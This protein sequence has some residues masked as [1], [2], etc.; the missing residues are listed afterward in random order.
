MSMDTLQQSLDAFL[1]KG[2]LMWKEFLEGLQ[3]QGKDGK[4]ISV[5]FWVN[6]QSYY[7]ALGVLGVMVV[8]FCIGVVFVLQKNNQLTSR[9]WDLKQLSEYAMGW[10]QQSEV[11]SDEKDSLPQTIGELVVMYQTSQSRKNELTEKLDFKKSVYTEFLKNLLLPSLNIWKDPYTKEVDLS[12]LGKKYLDQNPYQDISLLSQW[13][14]IIKDSGKDVWDNEVVNMKIGDIEELANGFFRI[15]INIAFKSDSK[16]AFLLLVD[17]LSL[18]SNI[19]NLWLL[20]DFTYYLFDVIRTQKWEEIHQ[21]MEEYGM[22][23]SKQ[24][25][26]T[27]NTVISRY[28]YSW[29]FTGDAVPNILIDESVI[30]EAIRDSIVCRGD[31]SDDV[32]YFMFRNKYRNIPWLAYAI[33]LEGLV[34]KPL[35]LKKFY[36]EIPPLI[37]IESFTF[38]KAKSQGLSLANTNEYLWNINFSIY[39]RGIDPADA[40]EISDKLTASCF[41]SGSKNSLDLSWALN[42]VQASILQ[43]QKDGSTVGKVENRNA[44]D[45]LISRMANLIELRDTLTEDISTYEGLSPYNKIIKNF[46]YYRMLQNASLCSASS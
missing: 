9:T 22:S 44:D 4:K 27:Y 13:S 25:E 8:T 42:Q 2:K 7:V 21:L 39:G 3:K 18:T 31:Q 40:Q 14:S 17:K 11:M 26:K 41:A 12:I 45:S 23:W 16:R 24:D 38:D 33:G 29:I 19:N 43:I 1:K 20:N 5:S 6:K 32:C 30:D 46:E 10:F 35:A 37:A 34:N 36:A 15:P 28:L